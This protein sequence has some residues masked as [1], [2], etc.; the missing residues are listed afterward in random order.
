MAW[1]QPIVDQHSRWV[2]PADPAQ[3][4]LFISRIPMKSDL[5]SIHKRIKGNNS[6][7]KEDLLP[8]TSLES[9]DHRFCSWMTC[10]SSFFV[11]PKTSRTKPVAWSSVVASAYQFLPLANR[12]TLSCCF[13]FR[14]MWR[15]KMKVRCWTWGPQFCGFYSMSVNSQFFSRCLLTRKN[16]TWL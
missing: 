8:N 9:R 3:F 1:I 4:T 7:W 15:L 11:I 13:F 10:H 5:K 2:S 6:W 12:E 14:F 16:P